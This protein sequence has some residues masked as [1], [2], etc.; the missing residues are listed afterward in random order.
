MRRSNVTKHNPKL[1]L[2]IK[3][4]CETFS[5]YK[6]IAKTNGANNRLWNT[7]ITCPLISKSNNKLPRQLNFIEYFLSI[8][9][10]IGI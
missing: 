1:I 2:L 9:I 6:D 3:S 7:N 8:E 10:T 5:S 4:I